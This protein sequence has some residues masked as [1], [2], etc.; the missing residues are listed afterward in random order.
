MTELDIEQN[1]DAELQRAVG[2]LN[3]LN[4]KAQELKWSSQELKNALNGDIQKADTFAAKIKTLKN[5]I[6]A[7]KRIAVIM[8]VRSKTAEKA[9]H[10]QQININSQMLEELQGIRREQFLSMLEA[11]EFKIKRELYLQRAIEAE[12][13]Q[14]ST[15]RV[16]L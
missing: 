1:S 8:G 2:R 15:R 5:M 13:G 14:T 9:A 3:E 11:K 12:R 6:A 4:Q 16:A 10:L 7:S